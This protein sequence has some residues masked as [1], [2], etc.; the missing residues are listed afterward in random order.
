MSTRISPR[1]ELLQIQKEIFFRNNSIIRSQALVR[2]PGFSLYEHRYQ[3][4]VRNYS[5]ISR[6]EE[7][8]DAILASD[9]IYVGDYHT[10]EQSQRTL[11]RLLKIVLEK[12][13]SIA[14]GL[15][16]VQRSHQRY[17]DAYIRGEMEEPDFLK[18]INFKKYWY[19]DLWQNF[20]PIFDFARFHRISLF[21]VEWSLTT[22]MPLRKRDQC[23]AHLI[24]SIF[25]KNHVQKLFV[26]MGDLHVAPEHLPHEVG[27]ELKERGIE[28]RE[29][30]IY[31]NSEAI[32]WRLAEQELEHK[33]EIVRIS[34]KEFCII[35]TPPIVWQQSY[36]NWLEN[37]EGAID[38]ADA[39]HS[40]LE[41]LDRISEFLGIRPPKTHGDRDDVEVFTCGDLSFLKTL[42]ED[43]SLSKKD[44]RHIKKQILASESYCLPQKGTIY[45]ANLS[46]NHASEEAAH[47]LKYLCSGPEGPRDPVDAFYT[48]ILHEALG[49]FG[50]KIINH[51]RKCFH[52]KEYVGLLNYF[53]QGP[54]PRKRRSEMEVALLVL[55]H[56][57]KDRKA[58]PIPSKKYFKSSHELFFGVTHG[59]GYML[60]DKL[61]YA[62]LE[63]KV[64]KDEIRELFFNPMKDKGEPFQTYK[65][66]LRKVRGVKIPRRV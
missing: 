15:E 24:R 49:F 1:Q 20:K 43:E 37:E 65:K 66:L 36:L 59:L 52:E 25:E 13:D 16:L 50:S 32:Y 38:F 62:L 27:R 58:I 21:A 60:G 64:T 8:L 14:V 57:E 4:H 23:S 3:K 41:L 47:Y 48:N 9:V 19:F 18:K 2:E 17:L 54:V 55:D 29:L 44:I 31:Q 10:N 35:N 6:Q 40:F 34:D 45:L 33:V 5:A 7:L 56:K 46:I 28:K 22:A 30:I 11:L 42:S 39:K 53:R 12:T 63:G 61:Y 51:K 26:F